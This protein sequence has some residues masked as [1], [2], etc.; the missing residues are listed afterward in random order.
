MYIT[1]MCL[2]WY[3]SYV[4]K[5]LNH[6]VDYLVAGEKLILRSYEVDLA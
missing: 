3:L 6:D 5:K 4:S 2:Q 1:I